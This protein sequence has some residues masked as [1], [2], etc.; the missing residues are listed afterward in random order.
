MVA[1]RIANLAANNQLM[2]YLRRTQRDLHHYELAVSTEKK[3]Q[4]Y[5]GISRDAEQLINIE[6]ERNRLERFDLNNDQ[7]DLR[8]NITQTVVN[9]IQETIRSFRSQL[10]AFNGGESTD[11]QRIKEIQDNAFRALQ[12]MQANLNTDVNG[13][14]IFSGGRVNKQPV[15]LGLTDL[16]TFQTRYDGNTVVYPWTRDAHVQTNL[17]TATAN[18]GNLTFNAAAETISAATAGSLAA[19]PVGST[20]TVA[21][22]AAANNRNFTVLSNDGTTITVAGTTG[23]V[24]VAGDITVGETVAATLQVSSYYSG[25]TDTLTHRVNDNQTFDIDLNA[26]DPAFE[27]AIRAMAIVAQG[28]LLN[29]QERPSEALGLL[30]MSLEP[31]ES[32][33]SAYGAELPNNLHQISIDLGFDRV[34]INTQ[35]NTTNQFLAFLDQRIIDL[36]NEDQLEAITKMLDAQRSLEASYAAL[37]RIRQLSLTNYI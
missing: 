8:L 24:T 29:N 31:P 30:D 16:T 37:S 9:N 33:S 17:T 10:L 15:S 20:I 7:L 21:G 11:P 14:Y 6:N 25:D 13:Q 32:A 3:S 19:I 18:T 26:I 5:A 2:N 22:A 1:T 4:D 23:T 34:M 36:E 28:N 35:K 27:K 12:D